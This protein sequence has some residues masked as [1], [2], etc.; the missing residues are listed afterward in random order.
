MVI[1]PARNL[2]ALIVRRTRELEGQAEFNATLRHTPWICVGAAARRAA[3]RR[4]VAGLRYLQGA[5]QAPGR[6]REPARAHVAI[7]DAGNDPRLSFAHR[8]GLLT[9]RSL[10]AG[11]WCE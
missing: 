3:P 11:R 6:R 5:A 10:T 4:P 1:H 2:R 9:G 7:A 8:P